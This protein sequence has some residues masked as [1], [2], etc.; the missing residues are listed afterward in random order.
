M[1][2][3]FN[4]MFVFLDELGVLDSLLPFILVFTLLY[5]ILN[6]TKII[7]EGKKNFN[8][9]IAL[10]ISLMVVIPHIMGR[11]PEGQD[12]VVI[13]NTA[14][15]NVSILI[16]AVLAVL[17]LVGIFGKNLDIAGSSL[18]GWVAMG[19]FG[20]VVWIFGSAAGWF[21]EF[22]P[23]LNFMNDPDT[24]ALLIMLAVFAIVIRFVT[25]DEGETK[26]SGPFGK[27]F[28]AFRGAV[29]PP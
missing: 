23:F 11:F 29:K 20:A 5:A 18:A 3:S 17:L 4:D 15:P 2:Q 26:V 22:P 12:P 7:G 14:L 25:A 8:V 27:I 21:G 13:I 16:V 19:A 1:V 24:Q 10:I 6:K 9:T 28:D